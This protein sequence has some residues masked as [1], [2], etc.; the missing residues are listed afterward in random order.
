MWLRR[1]NGARVPCGVA[2]YAYLVDLFY[3]WRYRWRDGTYRKLPLTRD[4]GCLPLTQCRLR[5]R[6]LTCY[7]WTRCG[8][9]RCHRDRGYDD[10]CVCDFVTRLC[11]GAVVWRAR[12][13]CGCAG[14]SAPLAAWRPVM[15]GARARA[16]ASTFRPCLA[17]LGLGLCHVGSRR[18]LRS[19]CGTTRELLA[20]A[21]RR[22]RGTRPCRPLAL[23]TYHPL[24]L[25]PYA[26]AYMIL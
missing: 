11:C 6:C 26:Y 12:Y 8:A 1:E 25:Q 13:A 2:I 16:R 15:G 5:R 19:R 24:F 20:C 7:G 21:T 10:V 3:R 9:Q 17:L 14:A 18:R 4:G 23:P 22:A